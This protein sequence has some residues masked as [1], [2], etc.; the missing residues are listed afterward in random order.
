MK[1]AEAITLEALNIQPDNLKCEIKML[2]VENARLQEANSELSVVI[3]GER[4]ELEEL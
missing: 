2:Q 4:R 1:K 3:G